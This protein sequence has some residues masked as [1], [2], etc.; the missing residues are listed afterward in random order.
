MMFKQLLKRESFEYKLLYR[1]LFI[2]LLPTS[3]LFYLLYSF[4]LSVFVKIMFGFFLLVIIFYGAFSIKQQVLNQF[5]S[6]TNLMEAMISGDFSMRAYQ[7]G[8]SGG[9]EEFNHLLNNLAETLAEQCLTSK[10]KQI[11]L[12]KVIV[13]IDVAIIAVDSASRISLMN[14]AAE[15]LFNCRFEEM[16][17]WP[18]EA[19]GLQ[20][21]LSKEYSKVVEFEIKEHKKRVYI[22]TDEYFEKG[23]RQQLIFITDIQ[24][25]LREEERQAWQKLL[26]VLSHE[27]NNSLAP[28][29]SISETLSLLL[30]K[31]GALAKFAPEV[32]NDIKE[33]L[34]VITERSNS[35]NQFIQSYQQLTRLPLPDKT[36]FNIL[37]L[38]RAT[39]SL[40]D[41]VTTKLNDSNLFV[42]ADESQ[43]KH[44]LINLLKNARESMMEKPNGLINLA[45]EQAGDWIKILVIDEGGGIDN[46]DN[47]FVPFYTTK[48]QGSGIGLVLSR[49]IVINHGGDLTLSNR[50][51]QPGAIASIYLPANVQGSQ[52]DKARII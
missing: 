51:E 20:E 21:V 36:L 28:I 16:Q 44:V 23:V 32:D 43:L 13:Q 41:D 26:R 25:L 1:V 50:K 33:G 49:Q 12:H 39:A 27:I 17:N 11:L 10:E 35:L 30:S 40:F 9:L 31:S 29:A 38:M 2:A 14:P 3:F 7:Q 4:D 15:K 46:T 6:S 34:A 42:Y 8:G 47:L 5:R 52:R 18:L 24:K 48:A 22:H 45:W 19:L 37:E